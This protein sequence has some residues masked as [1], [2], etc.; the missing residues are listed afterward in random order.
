M[1]RALFT[2]VRDSHYHKDTIAV[3]HGIVDR[4]LFGND[5]LTLKEGTG[6]ERLTATE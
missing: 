6:P 5:K 4:L 3:A 2:T 1:V